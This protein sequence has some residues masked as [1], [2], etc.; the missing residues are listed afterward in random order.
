[1]GSV[2]DDWGVKEKGGTRSPRLPR[3]CVW[4]PA[5]VSEPVPA[6]GPSRRDLETDGVEDYGLLGRREGCG[7]SGVESLRP[8]PVVRV[9]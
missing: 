2:L 1:M 3:P 5:S 7:N 6:G 9:P 4:D 8:E